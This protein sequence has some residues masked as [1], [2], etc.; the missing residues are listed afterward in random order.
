MRW[1]SILSALLVGVVLYA[2]II[3]RDAL[4]ALAGADG[5]ADGATPDA[6]EVSS[7]EQAD[8]ETGGKTG[9][10]VSVVAVRS[11]AREVE[12][13]LVLRG[14]TEAERRVEVLS[15]TT[16]RVISE[17]LRRGA[18]VTAGEILCRLDPGTREAE[19]AEAEARLKEAEANARASERLSERGYTAETTAIANRAAL[20]SAQALIE[21]AKLE[22]GRLE[23]H[24]PFDGLIESD[25]AE[26]GALLQ[27]GS[28]CATVIDLDPIRFVGFV[29]ESAVDRI[30]VGAPIAAR[31]LSGQRLEGRVSF[32][33][34]SADEETRT[35]RVEAEI[36]NP[37]RS[38]RDGL[39]AEV[40]VALSGISAHL[41]PQS[42]LT[43]DD[44]GR[45]GIRFVADGHAV[46]APVQV[47]RDTVE[48]VLL[49][50][51]P[52]EIDV[53]VTGQDFVTDGRAVAVTYAGA[54]SEPGE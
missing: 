14:R 47:I 12:N 33:S 8:G 20:Q 21:Q 4:K 17:P 48:G 10:P 3:E 52:D 1:V 32:V 43:L 7:S 41:L 37:D 54:Q 13:G 11:Q 38:I 24:A 46:F 36:P 50:G 44:S 45:L 23:I 30:T 15:E 35:F 28:L 5:N 19:L 6:Q 25:T 2:F 22:I 27:P 42:A 16:G 31:L 26:L 49:A 18:T 29:A 40:T 34:R 39:T 53:I 9:G 51:L